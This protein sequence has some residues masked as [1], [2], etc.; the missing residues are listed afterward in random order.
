MY[1]IMVYNFLY[2]LKLSVLFWGESNHLNYF[3]LPGIT[4]SSKLLNV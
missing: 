1:E 4:F 3:R 2:V